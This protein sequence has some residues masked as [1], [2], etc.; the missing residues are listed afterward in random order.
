[1]A[2]LASLK[3][4]KPTATLPLV[5]LKTILTLFLGPLSPGGSRGGSGLTFSYSIEVLGRFRPGSGGSNICF[6]SFGFKRS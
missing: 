4:A 6:F 5:V 2:P 3:F 1:M